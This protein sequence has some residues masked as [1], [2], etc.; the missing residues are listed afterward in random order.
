MA[1]PLPDLNTR[2]ATLPAAWKSL[3]TWFPWSWERAEGELQLRHRYTSRRTH[4]QS[5]QVLRDP[6]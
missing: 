6:R 2:Y 1:I 5:W 4:Y 3:A